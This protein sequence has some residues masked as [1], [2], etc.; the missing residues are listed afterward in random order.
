MSQVLYFPAG[1]KCPV[2][3]YALWQGRWCSVTGVDGWYRELTY[4]EREPMAGDAL[5]AN[6]PSGVSPEE[7]LCGEIVSEHAARVDV[8]ELTEAR[9]VS[10]LRGRV[11]RLRPCVAVD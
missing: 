8:R 1:V 6:L 3:S 11:T 2:G 9:P 5:V 7:V 10:G 4:E